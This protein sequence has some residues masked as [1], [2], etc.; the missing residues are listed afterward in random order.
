VATSYPVIPRWVLGGLE[1]ELTEK[2]TFA[3]FVNGFVAAGSHHLIRRTGFLAP[4]TR[5]KRLLQP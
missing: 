3:E 5:N 1:T 4:A 2:A